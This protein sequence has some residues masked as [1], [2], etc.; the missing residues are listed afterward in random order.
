MVLILFS[1]AGSTG[2]LPSNTE[3]DEKPSQAS[4]PSNIADRPAPAQ[5][6]DSIISD[7]RSY[8]AVSREEMAPAD[9]L[10]GGREHR[11][12]KHQDGASVPVLRFFFDEAATG[13]LLVDYVV[14]DPTLTDADAQHL[15]L[16]FFFLQLLDSTYREKSDGI[17]FAPYGR[18]H[19]DESIEPGL[20]EPDGR[21]GVQHP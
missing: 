8:E 3:R 1:A 18:T 21:A 12:L 7:D 4:A 20:L 14:L 15:I 5:T 17:S 9:S 2:C 19:F 6:A 13:R 10:A 16:E 11:I